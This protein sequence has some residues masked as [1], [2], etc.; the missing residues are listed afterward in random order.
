M[1]FGSG[2]G[3]VVFLSALVLSWEVISLYEG[4]DYI[5][6]NGLLVLRFSGSGHA[7]CILCFDGKTFFLKRIHGCL[8]AVKSNISCTM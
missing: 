6:V 4:F 2:L 5:V 8:P 1:I 3:K 7:C